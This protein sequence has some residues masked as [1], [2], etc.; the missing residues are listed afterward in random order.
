MVQTQHE[1]MYQAKPLSWYQVSSMLAC[2]MRYKREQP[3]QEGTNVMYAKILQP[4]A[5]D[6]DQPRC[7]QQS[8]NVSNG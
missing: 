2:W 4:S 6:V 1:S 3:M 5:E 8:L 7:Q